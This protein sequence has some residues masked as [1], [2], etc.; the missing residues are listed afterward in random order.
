M[1]DEDLK[2]SRILTPN[3]FRNATA[4][5]LALS[6]SKPNAASPAASPQ[7]L[8]APPPKRGPGVRRLNKVPLAIACGAGVIVAAAVGY[9]YH[10]RASQQ[11]ASTAAEA[12]RACLDFVTID[13]HQSLVCRCIVFSHL[14]FTI[15]IC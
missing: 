11:A 1:I 5:G 15:D 9:T 8:L 3:A 4:V 14:F 2:P 6:G 13:D 10:L 12:E 7:S